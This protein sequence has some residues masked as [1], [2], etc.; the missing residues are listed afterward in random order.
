MGMR[1]GICDLLP[2][3]AS[4]AL[5]SL[6]TPISNR[7]FWQLEIDGT[8]VVSTTSLFLIATF[9]AQNPATA[10]ADRKYFNATQGTL[11]VCSAEGWLVWF[12]C[13]GT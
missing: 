9:A 7:N 5:R 4:P 12:R 1:S 6:P 11:T 8:P 10:R 13:G 2:E 3:A